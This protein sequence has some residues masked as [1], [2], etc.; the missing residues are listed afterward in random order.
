MSLRTTL[1]LTVLVI[2]LG[3]I[4]WVSE[5]KRRSARYRGEA[6]GQVWTFAAEEVTQL[7]VQAGDLRAECV[8]KDHSW[9]LRVPVQCR[10]DGA[11]IERL[12]SML[13]ALPRREII[14][15]QDR[16]DRNLTLEDYG[17]RPPQ[18]Q[19]VIRAQD[20]RRELLVGSRAPIGNLLYVK[21]SDS[22]DVIATTF[23]GTNLVPDSV[24][25]LRDR[26]ILQGD[27]ARIS[28]IEIRHHGVGFVQLAQAG[29]Q[30][31]IQQ[32]VTDR[33][34]SARVSRLLD[35]LFAL[36]VEQF[37]WDPPLQEDSSERQAVGD[38]EAQ[39]AARAETYGLVPDTAV[40]RVQVWAAGDPVGKEL[41]LGKPADEKGERVYAKLRDAP[42][43][44]TV[45]SNAVALLSPG[46][47]QFRD[48]NV[49]AVGA[50]A[51]RH[52]TLQ[53][54][55]RKLVL[56]RD[57][58]GAWT[59]SEPLQCMADRLTVDNALTALSRLQVEDFLP[60]TA[61]TFAALGLPG[62]EYRIRLAASEPETPSEPAKTPL[63][64]T[65]LVASFAEQ[66]TNA[67]ATFDGIGVIFRVNTAP[68]RLLGPDI[69]NPLAFRDRTMLAITPDNVTRI[70]LLKNGVEQ[71]VVRAG[72]NTWVPSVPASNEINRAAIDDLLFLCA[73][74]RALGIEADNPPNAASYG[75]DRS[76]T[77]L[78]LGLR[79]D[80]GIQ[81]TLTIGFK[82]R[83]EGRFAMVQGDDVVFILAN[84]IADDLSRDLLSPVA[85]A[86]PSPA[87]QED[88]VSPP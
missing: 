37:V 18:A 6:R 71:S 80:E 47:D 15:A 26:G 35:G 66:A 14:T 72:T 33:A 20:R 83:T 70:T 2:T 58:A 76:G 36:R 23:D 60:E 27:A 86:K 54:G 32:P 81:K 42:S 61:T 39:T 59:I 17:L 3:A 79:G 43:I 25:M 62:P 57:E 75:L 40:A 73:N 48:R 64:D 7:D 46:V 13:E 1:W 77:V 69:T 50:D 16:S 52:V 67:Y 4:I 63:R 55:D 44:F 38:A 8:R 85:V 49:F 30:W 74:L 9:F 78:T 82:A 5:E 21:T 10:A 11:R 28:R 22:D 68:I 88:A 84:R 19:F 45:A 56:Q 87:Q 12:L 53:Q 41:L 31:T 34:D 29:G 24:Q 51:I 65:L